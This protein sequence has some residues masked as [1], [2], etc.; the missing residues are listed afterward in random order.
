MGVLLETKGLTKAFGGLVAVNSVDLKVER[1]EVTS[2]IGPNGAGKTTLFNLLSGALSC[3]KGNIIFKEENI[4]NLTSSSICRKGIG[5]SFQITSIFP[6]F[7]VF[8]NLQ[9]AMLTQ[10]RK[11]L[12]FFSL[13][14]NLPKKKTLQILSELGLID[15]AN[16][17]GGFLSHGDQKRLDIALALASEPELLLLDEPTAGLNPRESKEIMD[18]I[19]KVKHSRGMTV[20]FIEHDMSVVFSVSEKI[21]VMHLGR[22]IAEG[23]PDEIKN[24]SDVKRIY[25]GE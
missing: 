3:D 22:L 1:G 25:L 10:S 21:R 17:L 15:Q 19:Y 7:T 11:N 16:S 5:R 8:R 2:I 12:N 9:L 18:L 13:A 24:N 14:E 4:T 20:L 6:K 23:E